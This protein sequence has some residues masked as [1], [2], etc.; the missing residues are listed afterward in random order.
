MGKEF[1]YCFNDL[2]WQGRQP[3]GNVAQEL[4]GKK[5]CSE[6]YS[7]GL[8]LRRGIEVYRDKRVSPTPNGEGR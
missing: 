1:F 8:R 4:D 7:R 3:L 5:L 2:C 6:C